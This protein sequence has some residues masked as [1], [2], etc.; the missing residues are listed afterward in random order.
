MR[1][2]LNMKKYTQMCECKEYTRNVENAQ[3]SY[4]YMLRSK[5]YREKEENIIIYLWINKR[6]KSR[7][8]PCGC[9]VYVEPANFWYVSSFFFCRNCTFSLVFN[10]ETDEGR[11]RPNSF[12][13]YIIWKT[14]AVAWQQFVQNFFPFN[15][16]FVSCPSFACF[17]K[18][19]W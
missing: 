9:G 7:I 16:F 5:K 13:M 15:F 19:D 11:L 10:F 8:K 2:F 3:I 1:L 6:K 12:S 18:W 14:W 17:L 4:V